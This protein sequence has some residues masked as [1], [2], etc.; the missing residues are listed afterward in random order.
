MGPRMDSLDVW[1]FIALLRDSGRADEAVPIAKKYIEGDSG[2]GLGGR[3]AKLV[4][5]GKHEEALSLLIERTADGHP[6]I[7]LT[8]VRSTNFMLE[9][10][11]EFATLES[12]V[13]VWRKEQRAR[14]DELTA[15][16]VSAADVAHP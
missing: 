10:L 14:Y 15:A 11:P 6:P 12:A 8:R 13:Q 7:G 3:Y 9:H 5:D 2:A 1:V 4:L 16:R